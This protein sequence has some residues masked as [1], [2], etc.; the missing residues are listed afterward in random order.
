MIQ[1]YWYRLAM[2]ERA[3]RYYGDTFNGFRG[4]T[5]G[6][7]LSPKLFNIMLDVVIVHW[8]KII[9]EEEEGLEGFD[10]SV[11]WMYNLFFYTYDDLLASNQL[12]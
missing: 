7:P 8:L 12:E 4:V 11:Q 1:K 9:S 6:D 10:C 5:Q 2:V 3:S